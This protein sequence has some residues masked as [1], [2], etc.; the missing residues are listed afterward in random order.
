MRSEID[1]LYKEINLEYFAYTD[2][3]KYSK[4]QERLN[5]LMKISYQEQLFNL[6][7]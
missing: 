4:L 1:I 5:T 3:Y 7:L 2:E 6:L